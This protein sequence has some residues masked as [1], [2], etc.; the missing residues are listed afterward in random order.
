MYNDNL[1]LIKR[2]Q[3]GEEA[4]Y[5]L[6]LKLYHKKLFAYVY[7]FTHNHAL[8]EDIIQNVFLK[9]W[10]YR[11][12]LNPEYSIKN[13]LY[14]S[15]YNEFINYYK[16]NNHLTPFDK[17]YLNTVE[18]VVHNNDIDILERKKEI[19]FEG[20]SLL[21]EKCAEIFMLSKKDGLSNTEIADYL[22]ISKK[23]VEGHLTK[24]YSILREQLG[25]KLMSIF[26]LL[27]KKLK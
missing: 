9:L 14:K 19:I 27:F 20:V 22:K 8:T 15:C 2:L 7:T 17:V 12:R 6:L 10:E 21:P 4:G 18:S 11:S 16:K 3:N 13:F 5:A 26:F 25:A 1:T 24:A 23:T